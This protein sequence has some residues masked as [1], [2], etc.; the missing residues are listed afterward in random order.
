MA[1]MSELF[2]SWC[3]YFHAVVAHDAAL[4]MRVRQLLGMARMLANFV[5]LVVSFYY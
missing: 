1:D 5:L 4:L 2:Y 3:L